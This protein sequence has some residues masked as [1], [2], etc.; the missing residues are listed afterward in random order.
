MKLLHILLALVMCL[1][2]ATDYIVSKEA[3]E[4]VPPIMLS[5][6]RFGVVAL[7]TLPFC[8]R[9]PSYLGS[10]FVLSFVVSVLTYGFVDIGIHLNSSTTVANLIME[11]NVILSI[12]FASLFLNE[13]ISKKT[14]LGTL[15]AFFGIILIIFGNS[16]SFKI[17]GYELNKNNLLSILALSVAVCAWPVYTIS[18]KKLEKELSTI[19]IIAWT[20]FIGSLQS[21][22]VSV[23]FE[24]EEIKAISNLDTKN[25]I[26]IVYTGIGGVIIPHKIFHYLIR[27]YDVTKVSTISLFVPLFVAVGSF[28]VFHERLGAPIII[29]GLF[30]MIGVYFTNGSV[31]NSESLVQVTKKLNL[32]SYM[33]K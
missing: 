1:T 6:L 7:F 9:I 26:L 27:I 8:K 21:L 19:E 14:V 16:I 24:Y 31:S 30:I 13:K 4:L 17:S 33:D 32:K 18:A 23:I 28:F 22:L 3:L 2:Y 12:V 11:C 5:A 25:I 15:I 29:G 10:L 20:A